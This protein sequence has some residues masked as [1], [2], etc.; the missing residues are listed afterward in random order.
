MTTYEEKVRSCFEKSGLIFTDEELNSIEYADFGLKQI[1]REGLNLIVY[2]NCP[3]YCAKEMVLLPEQTCPQHKHPPREGS[4]GKKETFRIRQ[5]EV[6]LFVDD[7]S[8]TEAHYDEQVIA[9]KREFYSI[10]TGIKLVAGEQYTILPN[11]LHW[12][13]AG[14]TGAIVSEFS[15]NSDDASDIFTDPAIVRVSK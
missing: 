7:S 10:K 1:E 9:D 8:L 15:S 2:I 11:T 6:Y 14:P 4:E 3:E 5:G 13:K 12:F